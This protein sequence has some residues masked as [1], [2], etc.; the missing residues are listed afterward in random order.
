MARVG[1]LVALVMTLSS[2]ASAEALRKNAMSAEAAG[3]LFA[4][5]CY[6]VYLSDVGAAQAKAQRMGFAYD[7]ASGLFVNA[8]KDRQMRI[9]SQRCALRF[10]TRT[11]LPDLLRR[12]A[13]SATKAAKVPLNPGLGVHIGTESAGNGLTRAAAKLDI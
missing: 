3:K 1:I 5:I 8:R 12:F 2:P 10:L 6:D 13:S 7:T 11:P 9:N 4:S